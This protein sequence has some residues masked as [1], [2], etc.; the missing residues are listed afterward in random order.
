MGPL[1][2]Q[3]FSAI[4]AIW[5]VA[6]ARAWAVWRAL[7]APVLS[8][9]REQHWESQ[10]PPEQAQGPLRP[11]LAEPPQAWARRAGLEFLVPPE[12]RT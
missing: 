1:G 6:A 4:S 2:R 3:D 9:E 5:T 8:P 7:L 11:V 12:F 10:G